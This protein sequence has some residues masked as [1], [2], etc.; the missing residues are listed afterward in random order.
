MLTLAESGALLL[1]HRLGST[2]SMAPP[3]VPRRVMQFWDRLP[4]PQ[5]VQ[6]LQRNRQLCERVQAEHVLFDE[7]EA[8]EFLHAHGEVEALAAYDLAVHPAMKC[9]VFRLCYLF[10]SGGY[11]V[12]ADIVLRPN[13]AELFAM[14]G[15]L[16]VFQW[17]SR[18]ID[19][20][21]NWLIGATPQ[22]PVLRHAVDATVRSVTRA[23]KADP[24]SA[25]RNILSVSGPG[26][27]T[28]G[29]ATALA[30]A[31]A[32]SAAAPSAVVANVR[33]EP[34]SRAHQLIQLGPSYL[35]QPLDY[36]NKTDTRHWQ[37]A[38][39]ATP[40]APP[41][42]EERNVRPAAVPPGRGWWAR[43]LHRLRG[44]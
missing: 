9:D 36:K 2:P 22:Q 5:I 12:D 17:D 27:F 18:G 3:V 16:V 31:G 26:I 15:E 6:L 37:A 23:C 1:K 33:V 30:K 7:A 43:A 32:G 24:E 14:P 41:E 35:K 20:L 21:C 10:H 29:I 42:D 13:L 39:T 8:R 19:N 28:Q 44:G 4:P 40:P 34:V 11:Y 25:L 38:A